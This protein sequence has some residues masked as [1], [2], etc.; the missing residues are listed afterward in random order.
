MNTSPS[1]PSPDVPDTIVL[2]VRGRPVTATYHRPRPLPDGSP[3]SLPHYWI[4]TIDGERYG[5]WPCEPGETEASVRVSF[6]K[7][8]DE[9]L[10]TS[11]RR[12]RYWG[13]TGPYGPP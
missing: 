9:K 1:H 5:G 4:V 3:S 7:W 8:I 10:L 2:N 11:S 6:Q 12:P 13:G